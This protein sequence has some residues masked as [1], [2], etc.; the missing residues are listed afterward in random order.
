[1]ASGLRVWGLLPGIMGFPIWREA[2]AKQ[3]HHLVLRRLTRGRWVTPLYPQYKKDITLRI[4]A[5]RGC[6]TCKLDKQPPSL[7]SLNGETYVLEE[8][9][10]GAGRLCKL[11]LSQQPR[12]TVQDGGM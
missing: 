5:V 12:G 6:E 11:S 2:N 1:M 9:V 10:S 4:T 8:Q 3:L 7:W